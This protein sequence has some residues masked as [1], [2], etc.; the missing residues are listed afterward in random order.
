MNEEMIADLGRW[1]AGELRAEGLRARHPGSEVDE[2][3]EMHARVS[4]ATSTVEELPGPEWGAVESRLDLNLDVEAERDQITPPRRRRVP[5]LKLVVAFVAGALVNPFQPAE[6]AVDG[7]RAVARSTADA[8]ADE[9]TDVFEPMMPPRTGGVV[10]LDPGGTENLSAV[11]PDAP[12]PPS[13]STEPDESTSDPV[14]RGMSEP[15][16]PVDPVPAESDDPAPAATAP[17][18]PDDAETSDDSETTVP[19]DPPPEPDD[20]PP[21]TPPGHQRRAERSPVYGGE[22]GKPAPPGHERRPEAAPGP[23]DRPSGPPAD[24][25]GQGKGRGHDHGNGNGNGNAQG[26]H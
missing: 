18:A 11:A 10:I 20:D 4:F 15:R 19:S 26:R 8:V 23:K 1:E 5:L 2:M 21:S 6:K 3:L 12:P 24:H 14:P 25:P 13:G 9:V 22:K 17:A 16:G 7:M